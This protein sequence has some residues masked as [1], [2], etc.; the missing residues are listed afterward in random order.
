[1]YFQFAHLLFSTV[2][3]AV[4]AARQLLSG[5]GIDG[6]SE[7]LD[8]DATLQESTS[9]GIPI[10]EPRRIVHPSP[11]DHI[12]RTGPLACLVLI[13]IDVLLRVLRLAVFFSATHL[14]PAAAL[15]AVVISLMC[16]FAFM[17]PFHKARSE[18][19]W[20][21][22]IDAAHARARRGCTLHD[23]INPFMLLLSPWCMF[24][25]LACRPYFSAALYISLGVFDTIGMTA[26][27][28][29]PLI[30]SVPLLDCPYDVIGICETD[31]VPSSCFPHGLAVAFAS[32]WAASVLLW[33]WAGVVMLVGSR[34]DRMKL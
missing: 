13:F 2:A 8:S 24:A 1:M 29:A 14:N 3:V 11:L 22:A 34:R 18:D 26:F 10:G 21:P 4:S 23:F 28:A 20:K 15:A 27:Y 17:G 19:I 6:V 16:A 33:L 25:A 12:A 9:I 31:I 5:T 30:G 7:A 32:V